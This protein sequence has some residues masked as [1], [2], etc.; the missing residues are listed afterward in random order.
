LF[1]DLRKHE[2]WWLASS[3]ADAAASESAR[4]TDAAAA[5]DECAE[6]RRIVA[7]AAHD[8]AACRAGRGERDARVQ[9][10]QTLG[11]GCA[12]FGALERTCGALE[13]K[14]LPKGKKKNPFSP[15]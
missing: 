2:W 14:K 8:G 5:A 6:W 1:D 12:C 7:A 4:R 15:L 11:R 3:V 10:G 13:E 9:F